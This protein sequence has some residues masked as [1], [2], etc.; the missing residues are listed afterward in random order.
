MGIGNSISIEG[1]G[2]E[3]RRG[4][5]EGS[6]YRESGKRGGSKKIEGGGGER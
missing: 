1:Y 6:R 3:G 5:R 2:G 4:E